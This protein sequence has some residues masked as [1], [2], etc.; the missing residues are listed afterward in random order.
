MKGPRLYRATLGGQSV[1]FESRR[2]RRWSYGIGSTGVDQLTE[3]QLSMV[4]RVAERIGATL[5]V[6][7]V[8]GTTATAKLKRKG[9]PVKRK[10]AKRSHLFTSTNQPRR[11][12]R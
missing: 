8:V 12:R 7:P 2:S 1:R 5:V 4:R 3:R 9:A 6:R 10:K 11:R